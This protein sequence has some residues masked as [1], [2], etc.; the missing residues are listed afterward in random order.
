MPGRFTLKSESNIQDIRLFTFS[1]DY[2]FTGR[3]IRY[4]IQILL[5][6]NLK[7]IYDNASVYPK[8]TDFLLMR[9]NI[10]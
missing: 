9:L 5:I 7:K 6:F 4:K 10:C 2:R 8:K 3:I 1:K